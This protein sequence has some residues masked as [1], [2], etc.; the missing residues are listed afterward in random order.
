MAYLVDCSFLEGLRQISLIRS[1]SED[2]LRLADKE[3]SSDAWLARGLHLM[4]GCLM[5]VD[6]CRPYEVH[7][8]TVLPGHN[9]SASWRTHHIWSC[10][11]GSPQ[12]HGPGL[13]GGFLPLWCGG[14]SPS[15]PWCGGVRSGSRGT[16][17]VYC[18]R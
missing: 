16:G 8:L 14:V 1:Q 11:Q 6:R 13:W 9:R 15:L 17:A 3:P 10:A 2:Y 18:R 4:Y 12:P 5:P 7:K